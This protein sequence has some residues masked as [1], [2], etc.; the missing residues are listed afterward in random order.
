MGALIPC[1]VGA[2][3]T[4]RGRMMGGEGGREGDYRKGRGVEVEVVVVVRIKD[5]GGVEGHP[6]TSGRAS[7]A[8]KD[9]P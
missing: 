7:Q 9:K 8:F 3:W 2:L 6:T 1:L 5:L 4:L